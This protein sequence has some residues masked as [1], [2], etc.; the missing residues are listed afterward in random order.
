MTEPDTHHKHCRREYTNTHGVLH[1]CACPN[2]LEE[3]DH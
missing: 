1:R 2:H 3:T